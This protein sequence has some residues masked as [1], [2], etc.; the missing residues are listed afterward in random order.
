MHS[1]PSIGRLHLSHIEIIELFYV[2]NDSLGTYKVTVYAENEVSVN[3][4]G[5]VAKHTIFV[6][7]TVSPVANPSKQWEPIEV[8]PEL[9]YIPEIFPLY[10]A[11]GVPSN[12]SYVS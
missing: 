9:I 10:V 1:Y 8:I 7:S 2:T 11:Q 4:G 12:E 5:V 6:N 3:V